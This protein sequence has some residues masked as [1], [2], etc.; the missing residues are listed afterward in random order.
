MSDRQTQDQEEAGT[1]VPR[2]LPDQQAQD[3]EDPLDEAGDGAQEERTPDAGQDSAPD[4][5][6]S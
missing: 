1:P 2:D 3:S 4:E 6:T 5:P